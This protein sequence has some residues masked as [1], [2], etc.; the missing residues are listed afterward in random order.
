MKLRRDSTAG[1]IIELVIVIG[2]AIGIALLVQ[3]FVVKPY[4]IPS[5]SM[6][7]TL[8]IGQRV[9]VDR[10]GERFSKPEVGDVTVF[11]PPTGAD[12]SQ[13]GNPGQGPFYAGPLSRYP[14]AKSTPT[15]SEQTFIKRIVAGPGDTIA[16]RDG[17]AVVNGVVRN[18]P[19][20]NA[21]GA[22]A[23]CNLLAIRIPA[24]HYF[25]MGDNRGQSDDSRFWGPVPEGWI[26]G[27]AFATYWPPSR[28]GLL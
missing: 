25:M 11:H 20:V 15:Q 18:E 26:I 28:I 10:V 12:I 13:C 24:G 27:Q 1:S 14:C 3:Q 5:G 8:D 6:L 7:P 16:V 9:L 23:E 19:Y 4:R 2:A 17:Y 22:G 21:C